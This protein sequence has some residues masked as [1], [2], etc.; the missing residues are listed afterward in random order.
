MDRRFINERNVSMGI[1]TS[2]H[3]Q[4]PPP[5]SNNIF[6]YENRLFFQS[7]ITQKVVGIFLSNWLHFVET[8]NSFILNQK[9][10]KFRFPLQLLFNEF[11]FFCGLAADS[12]RLTADSYGLSLQLCAVLPTG[13]FIYQISQI[14]YIFRT[15]WLVKLWFGIC[16]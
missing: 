8:K 15:V 2:V 6:Y 13:I 16:P 11:N 5:T 12:C 7:S 9:H 1:V 10:E 14:W 4:C 3:S